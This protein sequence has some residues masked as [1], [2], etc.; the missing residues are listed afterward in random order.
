MMTKFDL[1]RELIKE[2]I[3]PDACSLEGGMPND[4]YCLD[5]NGG[6]WSIYYSERGSRQGLKLFSS[7]SAACA[8]FLDLLKK[9]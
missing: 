2:G 6:E 4:A 5:E 1:Q 7:E 9:R 8:Y 3:R